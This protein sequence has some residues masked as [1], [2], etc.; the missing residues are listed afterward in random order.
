MV[1]RKVRASGFVTD[2]GEAQEGPTFINL[3]IYLK[4]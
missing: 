1:A 3:L 2:G 4:V